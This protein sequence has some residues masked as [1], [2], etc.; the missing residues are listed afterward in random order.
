MHE[1]NRQ[2]SFCIL[3]Y[4]GYYRFQDSENSMS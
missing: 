1:C 3:L 2:L 4:F